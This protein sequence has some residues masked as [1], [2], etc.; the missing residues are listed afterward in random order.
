[1]TH[2]GNARKGKKVH[3]PFDMGSCFRKVTTPVVRLNK[4]SHDM[5]RDIESQHIG[6]TNLNQLSLPDLEGQ[7]AGTPLPII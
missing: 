1:M 4:L 6:P 3:Q 5:F 2:N 7:I